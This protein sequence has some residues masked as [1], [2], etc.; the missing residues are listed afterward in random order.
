MTKEQTIFYEQLIHAMQEFANKI[1]RNEN[2]PL[3]YTVKEAAKVL[4]ISPNKAYELARNDEI[5]NVKIG[6]R[7][8]VPR[9][10]LEEFI[11]AEVEKQWG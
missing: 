6:G 9:K 2:E 4:K 1:T 10:K 8:M 11:N 5:P 7:V 3:V